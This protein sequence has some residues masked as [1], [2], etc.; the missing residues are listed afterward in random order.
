MTFHEYLTAKKIVEAGNEKLLSSIANCVTETRWREI[1][2]S[3]VGILHNPDSLLQS[4]KQK[5][6]GLLASDGELQRFLVWVEQK[7]NS[8]E[9]SYKKAAVRAHYFDFDLDLA[10]TSIFDRNL[11]F[12]FDQDLTPIDQDLT[13]IGKRSLNLTL[14]RNLAVALDRNLVLNSSFVFL[15]IVLAPVALDQNLTLDLIEEDELNRIDR[16]LYE[17]KTQ[18]PNPY[19]DS[20][21][22]KQ[23]SEE[24]GAN[25]IEHLINIMIEHRTIGHDW[26]FT[27][28]QKELLKKY[29]EANKLLVD[30]LNSDCG[31]SDKVRQQIEDTMILPITRRFP[32][33]LWFLHLRYSIFQCMYSINAIGTICPI[34][35]FAALSQYM[36]DMELCVSALHRL[37]GYPGF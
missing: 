36:C 6:D 26:R 34:D 19:E 27:D 7:S 31:V 16:K 37:T 2:L 23:Y 14:D 20:D 24:N 22:L 18:L 29:Y 4:M 35:F 10:F 25:W 17:L 9:V 12:D 3:I 28:S 13:P 32:G 11:A 5:I 8:A 33:Q 21:T 30:C 1:L 15:F